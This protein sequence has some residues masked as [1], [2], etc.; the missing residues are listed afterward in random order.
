MKF[1]RAPTMVTIKTPSQPRGRTSGLRGAP[2]GRHLTAR[3]RL[4]HMAPQLRDLRLPGL[5]AHRLASSPTL[6]QAVGVNGLVARGQELLPIGSDPT[7][8]TVAT[9]LGQIG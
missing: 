4:L 3:A 2:D 6:G 5:M 1:G 7:V 9:H 8:V